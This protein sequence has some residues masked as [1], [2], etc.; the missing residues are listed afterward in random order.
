MRFRKAIAN[1]GGGDAAGARKRLKEL[2]GQMIEIEFYRDVW[3]ALFDA[4]GLGQINRR[5]GAR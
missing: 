2:G 1:A 5:R 3:D 4:Y